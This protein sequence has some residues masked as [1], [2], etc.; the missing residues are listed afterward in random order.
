VKPITL[1][2]ARKRRRWT[3]EQLASAAGIRQGVISRL[4]TGV[5][6]DPSF[7]TVTKLANALSVDP[8]SLIFGQPDELLAS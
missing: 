2:V 4:E 3:Q 8:R 7:S 1:R 6:A 5:I